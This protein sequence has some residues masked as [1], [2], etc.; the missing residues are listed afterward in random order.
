MSLNVTPQHTD[1]DHDSVTPVPETQP[2]AS[3]SNADGPTTSGRKRGRQSD[4]VDHEPRQIHPPHTLHSQVI[5]PMTVSSLVDAQH[6]FPYQVYG[7]AMQPPQRTLQPTPAPPQTWQSS[8]GIAPQQTHLAPPPISHMLHRPH[9]SWNGY[10]HTAHPDT[11]GG[12]APAAYDYR[13]RDDQTG[14]PGPHPYYDPTVRVIHKLSILTLIDVD[15]RHSM[16]PPMNNRH[17]Y[18]NQVPMRLLGHRQHQ[19]LN[20]AKSEGENAPACRF[21]YRT[22]ILSNPFLNSTLY[23]PLPL[24]QLRV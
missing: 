6:Q 2:V 15:L 18:Q 23:S 21:V 14:W 24:R 13:Y 1:A 10:D 7:A 22:F 20:P 4:A 17:I 5:T 12:P 9:D 16:S 11:M 3:T 8:G 19:Q